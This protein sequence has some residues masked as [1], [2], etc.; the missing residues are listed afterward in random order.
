[1]TSPNFLYSASSCGCKCKKPLAIDVIPLQTSAAQ[2]RSKR[3]LLELHISSRGHK[4]ERKQPLCR[5]ASLR[6]SSMGSIIQQAVMC[7]LHLC[8][9]SPEFASRVCHDT[10]VPSLNTNINH[11]ALELNIHSSAHHLCKILIF[12]KPRRVTLGKT[13]HFVEE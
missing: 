10:T 5:Y 3:G 2:C 7:K 4:K 11:L 1:M 12:H 9:T 6:G 13:R 8:R